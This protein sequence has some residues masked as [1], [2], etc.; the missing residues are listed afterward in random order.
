MGGPVSDDDL[1][2]GVDRMT[3]VACDVAISDFT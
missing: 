1:K 2:L 3:A